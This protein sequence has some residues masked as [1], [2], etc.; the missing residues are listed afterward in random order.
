MNPFESP[1]EPPGS[2]KKSLQYLQS[3]Q[4]SQISQ[5]TQQT[6]QISSPT[7]S[8]KN[9]F[10]NRSSLKSIES[11]SESPEK[12]TIVQT[13]LQPSTSP[14]R[15]GGLLLPSRLSGRPSFTR[16]R[17]SL[18]SVTSSAGAGAVGVS[19]SNMGV[20]ST[21]SP[22]RVI[23]A[24]PVEIEDFADSDSGSEYDADSVNDILSEYGIP[25]LDDKRASTFLFQEDLSE[26]YERT[27][28]EEEREKAIN[29]LTNSQKNSPLIGGALVMVASVS[30][31]GVTAVTRA[32]GSSKG[33]ES[34]GG[35]ENSSTHNKASDRQ[36]ERSSSLGNRSLDARS[37]VLSGSNQLGK[38]GK[39]TLRTKSIIELSLEDTHN[40]ST[41][42]SNASTSSNYYYDAKEKGGANSS[43]SESNNNRSASSGIQ[44]F[45]I[46]TDNLETSPKVA[47][48]VTMKSYKDRRT[49]STSSNIDNNRSSS[50][51]NMTTI[52]GFEMVQPSDPHDTLTYE[53]G[54]T[55]NDTAGFRNSYTSLTQTVDPVIRM[56]VGRPNVP[57]SQ[58]SSVYMSVNSTSGLLEKLEAPLNSHNVNVT[59]RSDEVALR[60]SS[61]MSSGNKTT[62]DMYSLSSGELLNTLQGYDEDL[63]EPHTNNQLQYDEQ[64]PLVQ[65][66]DTVHRKATDN[67][68]PST[69]LVD[70]LNIESVH[71]SVA[72][73]VDIRYSSDSPIKRLVQTQSG[74]PSPESRNSAK[75][76]VRLFR[77][78][79]QL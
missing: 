44:S 58:E 65:S 72:K 53:P 21:L 69:P 73:L 52:S 3:Q 54:S 50:L 64:P 66:Q 77:L 11:I 28:K 35:K 47:N 5:S 42:H 60:N 15:H 61:N 24:K 76:S 43:S 27:R 68:I 29:K 41:E 67:N 75:N 36:L 51:Y 19:I 7:K 70:M 39:R 45:H 62:A 1:S 20:R 55:A 33:I 23:K 71:G 13:L 38:I 57:H 48:T 46:Y 16:S 14:S 17:S 63:H 10:K 79:N 34:I 12:E 32:I 22:S 74:K 8:I 4:F 26:N 30:T 31:P 40:I 9:Y 37:S 56:H 18:A 6:S 2:D 49:I 59:V 78:N 25:Q